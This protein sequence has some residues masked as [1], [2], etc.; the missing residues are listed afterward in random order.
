VIEEKERTT[1][2]IQRFPGRSVEPRGPEVAVP[3]GA[4][5]VG[6]VVVGVIVD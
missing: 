4:E 3:E 2:R 5:L 1:A 6:M